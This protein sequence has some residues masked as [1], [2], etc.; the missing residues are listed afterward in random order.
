MDYGIQIYIIILQ[1][2][3][4]HIILLMVR[5]YVYVHKYNTC[6]GKGRRRRRRG[7]I[8]FNAIFKVRTFEYRHK[9]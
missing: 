7:H 9:R 2:R 3:I 6:D 8:I 4:E 1:R 5:I